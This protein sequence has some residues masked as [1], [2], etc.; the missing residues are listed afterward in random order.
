MNFLGMASLARPTNERETGYR[1]FQKRSL[2]DRDYELR[3][4][5]CSAPA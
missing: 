5:A 3:F 2:A 4:R 1:A